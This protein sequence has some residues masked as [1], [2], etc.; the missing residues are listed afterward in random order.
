M[1][2]LLFNPYITLA[3]LSKACCI[4]VVIVIVI[5]IRR[6]HVESK[7]TRAAQVGSPLAAAKL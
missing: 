6:N 1:Q 5:I 7:L 2:K 3:L 4:V